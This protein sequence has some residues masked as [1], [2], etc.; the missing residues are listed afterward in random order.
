MW[1]WNDQSIDCGGSKN[2]RECIKDTIEK[3]NGIK[4]IGCNA[5]GKEALKIC[6]RE[7]PDVV[8][9]DYLFI[10]IVQ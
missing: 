8:L 7:I 10:R 4:V 1:R 5:N 3:D 9:M 6:K 2:S